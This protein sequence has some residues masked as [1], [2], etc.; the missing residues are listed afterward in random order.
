MK[1]VARQW[2]TKDAF[3]KRIK[4]IAYGYALMIGAKRERPSV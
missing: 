2:I 4:C 1:T 3:G